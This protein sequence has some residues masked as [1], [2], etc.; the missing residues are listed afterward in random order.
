MKLI[1]DKIDN[2]PTYGPPNHV[3]TVNRRLLGPFN[4]SK[5]IEIILGQMDNKGKALPHT[6][7]KMD[8]IIILLDGELRCQTPEEDI[9]LDKGAYVLIP[10]GLEHTVTCLTDSAQFFI[11]YN[12]P[13]QKLD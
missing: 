10:K 5:N 12:P 1:T 13:L 7:E 3:G 9:I 2:L 8:Q 11:I 6:H 4:G